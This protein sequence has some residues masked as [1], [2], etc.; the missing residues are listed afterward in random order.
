MSAVFNQ[1]NRN[2]M[3]CYAIKEQFDERLDGRLDGAQQASLA[4]REKFVDFCVSE[5]YAMANK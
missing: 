4:D 3:S 1:M 2:D 5:I